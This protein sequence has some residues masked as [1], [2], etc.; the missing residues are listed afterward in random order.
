MTDVIPEQPLTPTT[1]FQQDLTTQGQRTI[2]LIWEKTQSR[3]ALLVVVI[4]FL[5][6]S[7]LVTLVVLFNKEVSIT[8]LALISICLQFINLT[9][10]IVIGFY[11]SRTNHAAIGGIGEKPS[12]EYKGR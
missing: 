7:L 4:G 5:I 1:T 2:N 10:G 6:N 12:Q 11:F 8:Q 9:V 3:I